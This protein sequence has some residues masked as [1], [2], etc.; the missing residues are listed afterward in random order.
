[1]PSLP[2]KKRPGVSMRV[3]IYA[4][5]K[6]TYSFLVLLIAFGLSTYL[7]YIKCTESWQHAIRV[8][9]VVVAGRACCS[10]IAEVGRVADIRRTQ[11]PNTG[12]AMQYV[13]YGKFLY[14]CLSACIHLFKRFSSFDASFT[15]SSNAELLN[16]ISSVVIRI[17]SSKLCISITARF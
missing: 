15:H 16:G 14:L 8:G 11:P 6:V 12:G 1:M 2:C 13:T 4:S 3:L 10:H 5:A 17:S 7:F 9:G